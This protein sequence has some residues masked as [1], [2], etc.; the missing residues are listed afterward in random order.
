MRSAISRREMLGMAGAAGGL[1]I[2]G[3]GRGVRAQSARRIEQLMP[4]FGSIIG[5]AESIRELAT[6]YGGDIGPAEGRA[7]GLPP[8]AGLHKTHL[9]DIGEAAHLA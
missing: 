7:P 6:G 1:L 2:M 9:C 5:T 4:E 8:P 3:G